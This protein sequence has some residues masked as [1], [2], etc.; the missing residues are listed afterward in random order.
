MATTYGKRISLRRIGPII[1]KV[2]IILS[3]AIVVSAVVIALDV[4]KYIFMFPVIF[5]LG[6]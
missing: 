2:N 3:V 6:R 5:T 4:E 1:D